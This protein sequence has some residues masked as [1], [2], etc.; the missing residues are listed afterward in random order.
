MDEDLYKEVIISKIAPEWEKNIIGTHTFNKVGSL[1][2]IDAL[3]IRSK[4]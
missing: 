1:N 2:I 3:H 4:W